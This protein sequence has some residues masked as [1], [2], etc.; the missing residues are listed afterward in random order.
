MSFRE[1]DFT[2]VCVWRG[3]GHRLGILQLLGSL[4]S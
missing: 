4:L 2:T 1:Q 3:V